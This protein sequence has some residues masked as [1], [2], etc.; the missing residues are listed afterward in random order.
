MREINWNNFKAKF[1]GKES[2][3]FES[4]AYHLFCYEHNLGLGIFRFKNQT[5]IET[6]PINYNNQIVGFQAKYYDTKISDNKSD[7][8]DSIKKAKRKNP[9]LNI[10]YFYVN[11]EFSESSSKSGKDPQYKIDIEAEATTLNLQIEWRVPSHFEIQLA[12]TDNQLL[13]EHFFSLGKGAVD[14][15][16]A[17]T[18]HTVNI[19][20]PIQDSISFG[21]SKIQIDRSQILEKIQSSGN[22]KIIII[23]GEGGCGKTGIIKELHST[24][25]DKSPLYTFKATEFKVEDI[26]TFFNRYGNYN[27]R[28]F[29]DFHRDENDKI[30]VIDSAENLSEIENQE[31]FKEFVSALLANSWKL[32]FTTRLTYLDDLKFQF[33]E[34]YRLPFEHL[35][36]NKLTVTELSELAIQHD[37]ELPQDKSFTVLLTNLFYLDEYLDNYG[38]RSESLN[39][40][41][42]KKVLWLRKI[43]KSSYKANNIHIQ[44]ENCFLE[45]ARLRSV[46]GS[47]FV[48]ASNNCASDILNMLLKDEIIGYDSASGGYFITHD[49]YEEWALDIIIDRSF[50]NSASYV[51]FFSGIGTSLPIRRA[52]R[53]W[54]SGKLENNVNEIKLLIH[55]VFFAKSDSKFWDDEVIVSIMLSDYASEFFSEFETFILE[56]DKL[57]LRKICFLLRI[58][59]KEVDDMIYKLLEEKD[60]INLGYLFTKPK[61]TGWSNVIDL[62]YRK[63]SCFSHEDLSFVIPVFEDWIANNKRGDTTRSVALF[64]LHFYKQIQ[65]NDELRYS[66]DLEKNLIKLI[67]NG[68]LEIEAELKEILNEVV[69][70]KWTKH[71]DP[72]HE[73]CTR[74]LKAKPECLSSILA[75]PEQV[76]QIADLFWFKGKSNP[77]N[78]YGSDYGMEK[79][80]GL[81]SS[82]KHGYFPASALQTPVYML[83]QFSMQKAVDFVLNFTNKCVRMYAASEND[84]DSVTEI[85]LHIS[86][87]IVQKQYASHTL[88]QMYRGM[89]SP[90]TPYLLQSMHMALEKRLL[91]M[92]ENSDPKVTESWLIYLL[93][94]SESISITAV[95]V[96]VVLSQPDKFFELAKILFKT[97][98]LYHFD[99]F[100]MSNEHQS[101]S[102]YSLSYG[103]DYKTKVFGDERIKTCED[104]HRQTS[105]EN[106]VVNY[107]FFRNHDITD[108]EADYRQTEIYKIIDAAS[109]K[110]PAKGKETKQDLT[111]RLVLARIDR[112]NMKPI[113]TQEDDKLLIDFNP[114]LGTELEE[115]RKEA[116]EK[117]FN[118][119]RFSP[120]KLWAQHKLN[121]E[122]KYGDYPQYENN[123]QLVYDETIE[124]IDMLNNPNENSFPTFNGD[125][126]A[127][128][129]SALIRFYF[130]ELS[131]E[132]KIFCKTIV[133]EFAALPLQEGYQYQ[134]AD[135]V[136]VSINTLPHLIE[137]FPDDVPIIKFIF[138]FILF[139]TYPIGEYKRV[140][141]YAIEAMYGK[142]WS[143]SETLSNTILS[144]YLQFAPLYEKAKE[145]YW[146][147][148]VRFHHDDSGSV[149]LEQFTEKYKKAIE[150]FILNDSD[151]NDINSEASSISV[152]ETAFKII[153][154]ETKN[155]R[156]LSFIKSILPKLFGKFLSEDRDNELDYRQRRRFFKRFS[157]FILNREITEVEVFLEPLLENFS[158]SRELNSLLVEMVSAEDVLNTYEI[159]WLVWNK[160]YPPFSKLLSSDRHYHY[161]NEL[162]HTYLLAWPYW[163]ASA[164]QWHSLKNREKQFY[165]KIIAENGN[166]PAVLYS[167]SKLLNE[168]GSDFLDDGIIWISDLL[169]VRTYSDLEI[170]TIYYLEIII[171]KYI[172]LNRIKIK[173]N[174]KIK[175]KVLQILNSLIERASV[176]AYLL[177]EDII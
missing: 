175:D 30:V 62:A 123:P 71:R 120:L 93:K 169:T 49:I 78:P 108:Q 18:D 145:E 119:M 111:T 124:L 34:I 9:N 12:A 51:D 90:V 48:M 114:T 63:I 82:L 109:S 43:Q 7:I 2:S 23:S 164:K 113:V 65:F 100:R 5:G 142:L 61:G 116:V 95:V 154:V 163:Q 81:S 99:N 131:D 1:N 11:K 103:M 53:K 60:N 52:F 74:L 44:R 33:I 24:I 4:L 122:H 102:L 25:S 76:I 91:V 165:V 56:N 83:L 35:P 151:F 144:G 59:C 134:I 57:I 27:L 79:C 88:Y 77:E 46:S 128:T 118:M 8:I 137:G 115:Y 38:N 89:G 135:G 92:A 168:I 172:Y 21:A 150:K 29:V 149:V 47:F 174:L 54:L 105:L 167:I 75:L 125:I 28:D 97:I 64:A 107:Q 140:C 126:P 171:R 133:M 146:K 117:D 36:I 87:E 68:G 17:I 58:A 66:S 39:S 3:T 70:N 176:S 104:K 41:E 15:V 162:I 96:S 138:L 173:Q 19:L 153:P 166:H 31:P 45:I 129:C 13:F 32:I 16:N 130:W 157:Y 10:I 6:E 148:N 84:L 141:D 67:L 20:F 94:K 73:L 156:H 161:E 22:S 152:L 121:P 98:K 37:F 155:L 42:F 72:H 147:K 136:E 170:N 55:H 14:F 26:N 86:D 143:S 159:F 69:L 127:Y 40:G 112:R 110:L 106:L 85:E 132:Q 80:Y 50:I 160:I 101:K 177:R 139:D 158:H